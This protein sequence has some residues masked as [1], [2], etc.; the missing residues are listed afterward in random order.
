MRGEQTPCGMRRTKE[1]QKS[2]AVGARTAFLSRAAPCGG[3]GI[4]MAG[5]I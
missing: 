4:P 1:V 2:T 5:C 3:A